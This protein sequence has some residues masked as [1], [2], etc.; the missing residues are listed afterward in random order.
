MTVHQLKI[1]EIDCAVL[2]EGAAFMDRADVAARY[3][4]ATPAEVEAA[5][6]EGEPSGSLNLLLVNS[7]GMRILADVGFGAGMPGM[8]GTLRGLA[9]MGLSSGDI[10]IVFLTHFHSD[11]IAGLL[12][13]GEPVYSNARYI[14]AQA[15]WDEWTSRWAASGD[16]MLEVF[17]GLEDRFSFVNAGDEIA[18][19]VTVVGMEGHTLGHAGLL[20]ESGGERLLHV[21]D[22]LHQAFQF[23]HV[24]WHFGFDT[25]GAMAV[26]TRRQVLWECADEEI[27]TLFYHLEFPGL[28][29]VERAGDHFGFR[30]A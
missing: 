14:C 4:N 23:E 27:L 19:G 18:P 22:L 17:R 11:H 7:G 6:G 9:Q 20:V 21:V 3:P 8:G 28:G 24:N 10:D 29:Y 15:E 13:G 2:Q 26:E 1:G 30:P 12:D 16:S 25:D 5:M